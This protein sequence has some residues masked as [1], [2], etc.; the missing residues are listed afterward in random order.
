MHFAIERDAAPHSNLGP[1]TLAL[2]LELDVLEEKELACLF[3]NP[4]HVA[5]NCM[6][7]MSNT[8]TL[9][10]SGS[11]TD[12]A[13]EPRRLW[14]LRLKDMTQGFVFSAPCPEDLDPLENHFQ[15]EWKRSFRREWSARR[16]FWTSKPS[17]FCLDSE[18]A[19]DKLSRITLH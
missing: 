17:G 9:W 11:G 2:R 13:L 19:R 3:C 1:H 14:T 15:F 10:V 4:E 18:S 12:P 8:V 5:A 16:A 6:T 7:L